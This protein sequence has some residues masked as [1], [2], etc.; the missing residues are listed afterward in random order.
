MPVDAQCVGGY[1][2]Q[3][4]R[5]ADGAGVKR[6]AHDTADAHPPRMASARQRCAFRQQ[7]H[8]QASSDGA[9][10]EVDRAVN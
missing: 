7:R 5:E 9:R 4:D 10:R 6:G 3:C 8:F 1:G 2:V